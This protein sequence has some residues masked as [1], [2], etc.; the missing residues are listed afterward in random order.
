MATY[1]P[2]R[3][4]TGDFLRGPEM[5]ALVKEHAEKIARVYTDSLPVDSGNLRS[6]VTVKTTSRGGV[7]KD[8][9]EAEVENSTRYAAAIEYEHNSSGRGALR[10]AAGIGDG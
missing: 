7:K 6:N 10:K 4:G 1:R 5:Q 2:D 8:R 9:A 3:A